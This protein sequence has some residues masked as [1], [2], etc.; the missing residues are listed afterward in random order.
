MGFKLADRVLVARVFIC[1]PEQV[2]YNP[3]GLSLVPEDAVKDV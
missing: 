2:I 1:C 3:G